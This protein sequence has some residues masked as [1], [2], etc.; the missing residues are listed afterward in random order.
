[1]RRISRRAFL[2][3]VIAGA[4]A[5]AFYSYAEAQRVTVTRLRL[6]LGAKTA[7]L[8]DTHTHGIGL[9]ERQVL[10]IL[11]EESPEIILHCGDFIDEFTGPLDR[12]RPYFSSMDACEKYAVLGNHDYWCG[13]TMEL[14]RLLKECGFRVLQNEVAESG[15]GRILGVDWRDDR[16]YDVEGRRADIMLAHD[17]NVALYSRGAELILAGHTHGGVK[18]GPLTILTNSA[19]TRGLYNLGSSILYV[20]R[21]LG[22][23]IPLRPA[24]PLELVIIE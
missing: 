21:G 18:I 20:S 12:V 1:M 23:L 24:S 2:V 3:G 8:A 22:S 13:R 5:A 11:R 9:V 14:K 15:I 6:G 17:P 16:R 4:A 10:E 19:Y 7:F